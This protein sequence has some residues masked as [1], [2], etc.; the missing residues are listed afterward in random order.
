MQRVRD[1]FARPPREEAEIRVPVRFRVARAVGTA[2]SAIPES[3][4]VK[5]GTAVATVVAAHPNIVR[6]GLTAA[7]AVPV[8]RPYVKVAVAATSVI[9]VARRLAE[10]RSAAT[11]VVATLRSRPGSPGMAYAGN[12]FGLGSAAEPIVLESEKAALPASPAA[13]AEP[14]VPAA[15]PADPAAAAPPVVP[16]PSAEPTAVPGQ[17]ANPSADTGRFA[18]PASYLSRSAGPVPDAARYAN[19]AAFRA[20]SASPAIP[21]QASDSTAAEPD[22]PEEAD[23]PTLLQRMHRRMPRASRGTDA[24]TTTERGREP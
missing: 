5:M 1:R 20:Q 14:V 9:A 6:A 8:L 11:D 21:A 3:R 2:A 17:S 23:R 7:S 22:R 18:N 15:Q 4:A 16:A 24:A 10:A 19:P 12:E 13:S